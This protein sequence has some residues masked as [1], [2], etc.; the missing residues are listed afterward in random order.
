MEDAL[1]DWV[2]TKRPD[3]QVGR[4]ANPCYKWDTIEVKTSFLVPKGR[5]T[6]SWKSF[7]E[8]TAVQA[9]KLGRKFYVRV[10]PDGEPNAGAF[11]CWRAR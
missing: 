11:E 2:K 9:K 5:Q 10:V 8:M 3:G 4:P 7:R 1:P 6:C